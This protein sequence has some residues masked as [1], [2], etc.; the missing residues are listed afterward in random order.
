MNRSAAAAAAAILIFFAGGCARY[1]TVDI[2]SENQ[3]YTRILYR[4]DEVFTDADDIDPNDFEEDEES[5]AA[6]A[7][8]KSS[9]KQ[10]STPAASKSKNNGK[11]TEQSAADTSHQAASSSSSDGSS[12]APLAY[13]RQSY[14][15]RSSSLRSSSSKKYYYSSGVD[16]LTVS[17]AKS[18]SRTAA[19]SENKRTVYPHYEYTPDSNG[20]FSEKDLTFN[21][22]K[23]Y[24]DFG[25]KE[26]FVKYVLG[27]TR[28]LIYNEEET[29]KTIIYHDCSVILTL[30]NNSGEYYLS[31]IIVPY[32]SYYITSRGIETQ[33]PAE[34]VISTYGQPHEIVTLSSEPNEEISDNEPN[35]GESDDPIGTDN[36]SDSEQNV[37]ENEDESETTEQLSDTDTNNNT[38]TDTVADSE[39][40]SDSKIS[41]EQPEPYASE[42]KYVYK[43]ESGSLSFVIKNDEVYEIHYDIVSE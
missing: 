9:S 30:D 19:S 1:E 43:G 29:E 23:D 21:A 37:N 14:S 10:K 33:S 3:A 42:L 40:D 34:D 13:P 11:K 6:E 28:N 20:T 17:A 27:D 31:N 24:L 5:S 8:P 18:S 38:D 16:K 41:G 22:I 36:I 12:S 26:Q 4:D 39:N 15:S 7:S 32:E 2:D 35:G 25:D